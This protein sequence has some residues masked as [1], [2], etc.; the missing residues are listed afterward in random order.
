M[1]ITIGDTVVN[2]L[3]QYTVDWLFISMDGMDIEAGVTSNNYMNKRLMQKMIA[4]AKRK[5]LVVDDSIIRR[6]AFSRI[7]DV[8]DFEYIVTNYTERNEVQYEALRDLGVKV[9]TV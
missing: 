5:V 7:A 6:V 2:Q 9:I 4:Q 8:M 3:S 1:K